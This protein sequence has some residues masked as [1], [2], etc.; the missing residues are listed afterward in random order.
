MGPNKGN[1]KGAKFIREHLAYE[2]DDCLMW[3]YFINPET[4]YAYLGF[5]G[6][7]VRAHKLMCIMVHG[8]PSDPKLE[9]AHSCH[10]PACVNPKHLSWKTHGQNI[11]DKRANG[12]RLGPITGNR[13]KL[14]DAQVQEVRRLRGTETQASL[15]KRMD[16]SEAT[17]RNIYRG[18]HYATIAA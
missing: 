7:V 4:G 16:V 1:G 14:T 3:P 2:G 11:R 15:A 13:G 9:A 5:N 12:Q 10:T 6:K 18:K 8:E 17:I